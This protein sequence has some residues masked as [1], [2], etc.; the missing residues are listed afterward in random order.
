MPI[1]T[2]AFPSMCSTHTITPST[3]DIILKEFKRAEEITGSIIDGKKSWADLFTR[4]TFFTK[5]H[6]FYLS[7]IASCY[8]KEAHEKFQGLVTSKVR[9]LIKG[10]DE[11]VPGIE[12]ARPFPKE[13]HRVH[14]CD[15]EE[16]RTRIREGNMKF[17]V[18]KEQIEDRDAKMKELAAKGETANGDVTTNPQHTIYTTTY[19]IGLTLP[20]SMTA[21]LRNF[22]SLTKLCP[23]EGKPQLDISYPV[24]DFKRFVTSSEVYEPENM[25]VSVVL[26]RKYVSHPITSMTC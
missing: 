24:A 23:G 1:I 22:P 26:T 25:F 17:V 5:D 6:K 2:P 16:Q 10:I 4:H 13:F 18:T 12:F 21:S 14:Q 8:T 9:L 15:T 3:K 19:Y 7:V 11:G 20:I